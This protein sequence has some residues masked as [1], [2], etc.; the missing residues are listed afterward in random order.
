MNCEELITKI[1]LNA[2]E[3]EFVKKVAKE[4]IHFLSQQKIS[5]TPK[6]YSEWFFTFCKAMKNKHL[7]TPK[8]LFALYEEYKHYMEQT[9]MQYQIRKLTDDLQNIATY[10]EVTLIRFEKNV[11]KHNG[12]LNESVDAIQNRDDE[13]IEDLKNKVEQLEEENK[14]LKQEIEKSKKKLIVIEDA[15]KQQEKEAVHDPLTNLY[16]RNALKKEIKLLEEASLPYSVII[17]DI[18]DFKKIND[19]FGHIA[20][21]K[22]LREL[23]EIFH[24][25]V[26]KDSKVYRYGGEEF[27]IILLHTDIDGAKKLAQRLKEVISHH[28]IVLDD[29][30]N[31]IVTASFGI[32]QKKG[33]ESFERVLKRADQALYK[34]KR[35]GK[36][37]VEVS[38]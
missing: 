8:N 38:K 2:K 7:L 15:F 33:D 12:Y 11:E 31:I 21:D 29:G 17:I 35:D 32:A 9:D 22:V 5:L 26:R 20:G 3:Q 25:Y 10:S 14:K 16:N 6:N 28:T 18:D 13:R 37:R 34:A 23:G 19:T 24:T 27:L 4:T 36:N 30:T 1:V